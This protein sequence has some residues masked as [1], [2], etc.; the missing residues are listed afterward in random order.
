MINGIARKLDSRLSEFVRVVC[1]MGLTATIA[2]GAAYDPLAL[3]GDEKPVVVDLTV[4]DKKRQREI[5]IRVFLPS[6]SGPVPVL[7][8]NHGLGGS[9][10]GNAYLGE[11]W[12]ARG[13]VGVF[14]Q[15]LGSDEAVRRDV[16]AEQRMRAMR[17]VADSENFMLRAR[18]VP[19]VLDQLER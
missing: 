11:H 8:V 7:L 18:D 14:L 3:L 16:P 10:K 6:R 15:H 13:Y 12:A 9:R 2:G 5:P 17:K 1:L 4:D 19:V